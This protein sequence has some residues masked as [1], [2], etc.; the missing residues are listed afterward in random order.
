V[1]E[2]ETVPPGPQPLWDQF[3]NTRE[4]FQP[5]GAP[6][7]GFGGGS[8]ARLES[9]GITSME[10]GGNASAD[11]A[12]QAEESV[13]FAG[14]KTF[15]YMEDEY[16]QDSEYIDSG[17]EPVEVPY[18]SQQYYDLIAEK[19]DLA[20]YF[21]VAEKVI[22]VYEGTAYK[23]T[24]NDTPAEP[25]DTTQKIIGKVNPSDNHPSK[26]NGVKWSSGPVI[27]IALIAIIGIFALA[28]KA[29]AISR[30]KHLNGLATL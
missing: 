27:G 6:S 20:Q 26:G 25:S 17:M 19:P 24:P 21:A 28:L 12:P 1:T 10:M 30:A 4:G 9:Q 8:S 3:G 22:V 2:D 11:V 18:L 13:R 16:W 15:Y 23:V 14:D 7:G 29:R 5:P